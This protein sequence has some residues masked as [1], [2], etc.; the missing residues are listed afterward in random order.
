MEP[1]SR[2]L[3]EGVEVSPGFLLSL[4]SLSVCGFRRS[5]KA[6]CLLCQEMPTCYPPLIRVAADQ[7]FFFCVFSA[8]PN[9]LVARY[10][11]RTLVAHATA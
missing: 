1:I 10:C 7:A 6:R 5:G 4:H 8:S 11:S 2:Q 9:G 3:P